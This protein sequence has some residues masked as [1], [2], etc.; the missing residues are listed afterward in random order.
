M[1]RVE[2]DLVSAA[3]ENDGAARRRALA[4]MT[5][6]TPSDADLFRQLA[7]EETAAHQYADAAERYRRA[8][9]LDP[10]NVSA[11][12][13]LGY[14]EALRKNLEGARWALLEY[15]RLAPTGANP[16]DSLGDVHF[17]LGAFRDAE[18]FYLQAYEKD[19]SFLGGAELYKAARAR[20]MTGDISGADA[21]FQRYAAARKAARDPLGDYRRSQWLYTTGR[22]GDAVALMRRFAASGGV[23]AEA[24][25]LAD[26]QLAAWSLV[27]GAREEALEWA[28][29]A[30]AAA[31]SP[32]TRSLA[33]LCRLL[34]EPSPT[35]GVLQGDLEKLA[36]SYTLLQAKRFAE[37]VP[38]LSELA[39]ATD[40]M[41]A[42]QVNFLLAWALV[43]SGRTAEALPLV[44]TYG[45]PQPGIEPAFGC[46]TFPRIFLLKSIVL[47]KQGRP[48]EADQM[49][50][51]YKSLAG[52]T[53]AP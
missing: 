15:G 49:R 51:V 10:L 53:S 36:L 21:I 34:A 22:K 52:S 11:W 18:K 8:V 26:S 40:P 9:A 30:A 5:K 33:A 27:G 48:R 46:F 31:Q 39:A 4:A 35:R 32:S 13:E 20:L 38:V 25:S 7:R 23:A 47:E 14:T 44:E 28:S 19:N 41:S 42:D 1:A 29:R 12:N 6:L 37:A 17:Y 3:L 16:L 2:F 50:R 45:V 43:E 24:A